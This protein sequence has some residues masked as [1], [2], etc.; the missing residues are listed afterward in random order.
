M[1]PRAFRVANQSA[2]AEIGEGV[3]AFDGCES[4][5]PPS[6]HRHHDLAAG[7]GVAHVATEL[8]VQ[9]ADPDLGLELVG[10]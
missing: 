10:M 4:G 2:G 3:V 5:D 7:L 8:V 1:A 6:S 9:L